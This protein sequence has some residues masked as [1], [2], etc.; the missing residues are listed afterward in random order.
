MADDG[1]HGLELW[2]TDGTASGTQL[3]KDIRLG[4]GNS[5]IGNIQ[6]LDD[7]LVF[8]AGTNDSERDLWVSDGTDAGTQ[9]VKDFFL[10]F[11]FGRTDNEVVILNSGKLWKSDGTADG[12]SLMFDLNTLGT[13][14]GFQNTGFITAEENVY[15]RIYPP[16]MPAD[17]WRVNTITNDVHHVVNVGS[18]LVFT[19]YEF[20]GAGLG[21]DVVCTG[22][23]AAAGDELWVSEGEGD[24]KRLLKDINPGSAGSN[25][26][27]F[28]STGSKV[29][30][31]ASDGTHGTELWVTD[32]TVGGTTM[33]KDIAPGTASSVSSEKPALLDG[34]LVFA[35][36]GAEGL[37]PWISDG[38]EE[39]THILKDLHV[40]DSDP[41]LFT[42]LGGKVY[43]SATDA[44]AGRE[45]F[46][47]DGTAEG[48][49]AID[50]IPGSQGS[51]PEKITMAG[52]V[53]YFVGRGKIWRTLGTPATTEVVAS[54]D[55]A[56]DLYGI[57][58]YVLFQ[59]EDAF[60]G[61][62]LFRVDVHPF[63]QTLTMSPIG[64]K[65][66][67]APAFPV[68][69]V[70][71]S[72]FPATIESQDD[73]ISIDGIEVQLL[74]PGKATITARQEGI[75]GLNPATPVSETFCI[76]PAKPVITIES[77][78]A[79]PT[80]VSSSPAN[81]RWY[82]N[83][84]LL[85]NTDN[86]MQV[87]GAG[88]YSVVVS[89]E[90][91]DS[92]PSDPLFVK[93][94]QTLSLSPVGDKTIGDA[95]FDVEASSSAGLPVTLESG[96]DN[97][98]IDDLEITLL[99]PGMVTITA[100][101]AGDDNTNSASPVSTTFCVNPAKPLIT[102]DYGDT[103]SVLTSSADDGNQWY[104]DGVHF[105]AMGREVKVNESG[106][107]T[108]VASVDGCESAASEP[109]TVTI[110][111]DQTITLSP[112]GDKTIGDP[113]FTI[114]ATSSSGLPVSIATTN[115]NIS[116]SGFEVT[117]VQPGQAT[118]TASQEGDEET[119]EATPVSQTFCIRP[120]KPLIT[121]EYTDTGALLT[122]SSASNNQWYKDGILID[123]LASM[124]VTGEG[125]YGL[126]ISVD[127]CES[128]M[129][130]QAL[131]HTELGRDTN[132]EVR[133]YPNPATS[134][135]HVEVPIRI[136]A[137]TYLIT[138]LTGKT[139][140]AETSESAGEII[141]VS[142]IQQGIYVLW[143]TTGTATSHYL[144]LKP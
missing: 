114:E 8:L 140:Y 70:S 112:V 63:E 111:V 4:T 116:V 34:R 51:A 15:F 9:M 104:K 135:L 123:S 100:T 115:D 37:E 2:S 25:L 40:D 103:I 128:E 64:D 106:R 133:I 60:F 20:Q 7:K 3:I 30:F 90:G 76:L 39:G 92:D 110:K 59:S 24:S 49:K 68:G 32:G 139:V 108:V 75:T 53:I 94:T 33:L 81:N 41:Q 141:D 13:L 136:G 50:V 1:V 43:F 54:I 79:V 66:I 12:T 44:Q 88:L 118:I 99:R 58:D 57:P 85:N 142:T 101:Q 93:S 23:D 144:F 71:S 105:S 138:D 120:S 26:S 52:G 83:G 137:V 17:L 121:V 5:Y 6:I 91:C 132:S 80:L 126:I 22:Y 61:N 27:C 16:G 48:T 131:I 119:K 127:G 82:K 67:E 78:D 19:P 45:L 56:G 98:S 14:G 35:A 129:S 107:Y 134:S 72:G 73:N 143:V 124:E 10:P 89:V 65:T 38:T 31:F 125:A 69:A 21:K 46:V 47:T 29:F 95:P 11:Y 28:T 77:T 102:V 97:I 62:E 36:R 113:A 74:Q 55:V 86:E 130:E 84:V 117:L 18:D 42:A 96:D 109:V 122:S 87:D